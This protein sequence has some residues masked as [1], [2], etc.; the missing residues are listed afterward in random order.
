MEIKPEELKSANKINY[1]EKNL[2]MMM[3]FRITFRS[4]NKKSNV[5]FKRKLFCKKNNSSEDKLSK[6]RS[7]NRPPRQDKIN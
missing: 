2:V 5:R 7:W 6:K 3:L 1:R 4:L